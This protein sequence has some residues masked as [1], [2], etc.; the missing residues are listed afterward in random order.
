MEIVY[1][2]FPWSLY[3]LWNCSMKGYFLWLTIFGLIII[4][5]FHPA[6]VDYSYAQ[7]KRVIVTGV[8]NEIDDSAWNNQLVSRGLAQILEQELAN[9]EKYTIIETNSEIIKRIN[10]R[11]DQKN[12]IIES[13]LEYDKLFQT[14]VLDAIF[15]AVVKDFCTSR[16]RLRIG[17]FCCG[18]TKVEVTVQV[19][20]IRSS[21][22]DKIAIGVGQGT[23]ES[24]GT[25]FQI[26]DDKVY[27]DETTVGQAAKEAVHLAV[28]NIHKK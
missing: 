25:L 5:A 3:Y 18:N 20:L 10:R 6:C 28:K 8:K 17:P 4:T 24:L 9:S 2:R 11:L 21:G 23:T 19:H 16:K 15:Y 1:R 12:C 13:N 22:E 27:F 7:K 14:N 26:Q